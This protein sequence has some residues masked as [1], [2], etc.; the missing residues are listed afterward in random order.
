[1]GLLHKLSKRIAGYFEDEAENYIENSLVAYGIELILNETIKILMIMVVAFLL[2]KVVIAIYFIIYLYLSRKFA[3]GK[4]FEGQWSCIIVSVATCFLGPVL[5]EKLAVQNEVIILV[6]I[7][8]I[9]LIFRW[10]P[11]KKEPGHISES[12]VRNKMISLLIFAL[13]IIIAWLIGGKGFVN[14]VLFCEAV[15]LAFTR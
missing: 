13:G 4:H 6:T 11:Y 9:I 14:G 15:V 3:D 2:N 7:I 8:E 5:L 12:D 1:M 10:I